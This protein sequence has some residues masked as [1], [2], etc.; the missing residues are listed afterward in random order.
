MSVVEVMV[1]AQVPQTMIVALQRHFTV[2]HREHIQDPS[3]LHRVQA[4]VCAESSRVSRDWMAL[5]PQLRLICLTGPGT[6]GV[7][8]QEAQ[9]RQIF[10]A[11]GPEVAS[12]ERAD[13]VVAALLG[14]CRQWPLA[15]RFVRDGDWVDGA[16]PAANRFS[17]M[18]VGLLGMGPTGHALVTRLR[19][20]GIGGAFVAEAAE[21]PSVWPQVAD[22]PE[23][24]AQGVN[25][26]VI[27]DEA[28]AKRQGPIGSDVLQALLT[29]GYVVCLAQ[30]GVLDEVSVTAMLKSRKLEGLVLDDYPEAPRVPAS[31]RQTPRTWVTPSI[32]AATVQAQADVCQSVIANIAAHFRLSL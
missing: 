24:L 14:L 5:L 8:M 30:S 2:H 26:L 18:R 9:R 13:Y 20:F 15:D 21:K 28:L 32:S 6:Q 1:T 12:V 4:V 3:V 22:L 17:G 29:P 25:A 23:L 10:V 27:L 7:D 11:P 19:A 31:W 16:F